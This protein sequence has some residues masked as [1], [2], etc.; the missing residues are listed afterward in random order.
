MCAW[1]LRLLKSKE[2]KPK[3]LIQSYMY[4]TVWNINYKSFT[5]FPGCDL[6]SSSCT[7]PV[8]F[9]NLQKFLSIA[10]QWDSDGLGKNWVSK[11]LRTVH[12][13]ARP[14]KFDWNFV[15]P[16]AI[17]HPDTELRIS[18][19]KASF[20][21]QSSHILFSRNPFGQSGLFNQTSAG[22]YLISDGQ[23]LVD[24]QQCCT[25]EY[26]YECALPWQQALPLQGLWEVLL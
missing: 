19:Y 3:T 4:E 7:C 25:L 16:I 22:Q 18:W 12:K 26:N 1:D 6:I 5:H 8:P 14:V 2:F 9:A 11:T 17:I 13:T 21:N 10:K 23:W 15:G 24:N 20:R